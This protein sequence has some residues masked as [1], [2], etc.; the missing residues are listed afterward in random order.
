MGEGAIDIKT[1]RGWVEAAGFRGF[2]EVEIFSTERWA[3]DQDLYL[4]QVTD[5]YLTHV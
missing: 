4:K 1:I 3:I 5:A 2:N